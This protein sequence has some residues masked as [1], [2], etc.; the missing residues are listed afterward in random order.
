MRPSSRTRARTRGC[1]AGSAIF[2]GAMVHERPPSTRASI[3]RPPSP[4][5]PRGP[6]RGACAAAAVKWS[7]R[8]ASS[9]PTPRV[10]LRTASSN[11]PAPGVPRWPRGRRCGVAVGHRDQAD[12]DVAEQLGV[13]PPP[14]R[15][16]QGRT[17]GRCNVDS[18]STPAA[19]PRG[20]GGAARC[21]PRARLLVPGRRSHVAA[22]GRCEPPQD[23]VGI[24]GAFVE[25]VAHDRARLALAGPPPPLERH[26]PGGRRVLE[27]VR[28]AWSGST[29]AAGS[30]SSRCRP[31]TS[32]RT[33]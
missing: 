19:P 18:I 32:R 33:P 4:A 7:P 25:H 14:G 22:V 16:P 30:A 21:W 2:H 31:P 6:S 11:A 3:A 5:R 27:A 29:S 26:D 13:V 23:P 15:R 10:R 9:S 28:S 8:R 20:A 12:R 24:A 17:R 1:A